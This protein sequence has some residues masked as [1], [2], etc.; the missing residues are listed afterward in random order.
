MSNRKVNTGVAGNFLIRLHGIISVFSA[1]ACLAGRNRCTRIL[2]ESKSTQTTI[3][4]CNYTYA[5]YVMSMNPY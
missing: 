5:L 2:T 4:M 1:T 3:I